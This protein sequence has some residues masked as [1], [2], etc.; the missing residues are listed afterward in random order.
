[1]TREEFIKTAA[2]LLEKID[3]R[4]GSANEIISKYTATHKYI[5]GDDR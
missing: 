1:M 2:F 3:K 5:A 4:G